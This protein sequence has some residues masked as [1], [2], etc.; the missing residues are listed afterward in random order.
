MTAKEIYNFIQKDVP[1][2]TQEKWD[3]SGLL[4]NAGEKQIKKAVVTLDIS[5][6]AV[7]F[8]VDFGADI[9]FS[10]HPVIF[11][12]LKN[13]DKNNPVWGLIKNEISAVCLH[14]PLDMAKHGMN[15]I[16]YYIMKNPLDLKGFEIFE[17]INPDGTGFGFISNIG[18]K[19][20][21]ACVAKSLKIALKCSD[22]RY[23]NSG[24]IPEK[25]SV[26]SGSGASMLEEAYEMGIDTLVTGDVKQDRWIAAN[27]LGINL[28]D[29]GHYFTEN[30]CL[31]YLEK[32]IKSADSEIIVKRFEKVP[33]NLV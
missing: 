31:P 10:H 5:R 4:V 2:N 25:M 17:P 26:C 11:D 7:E 18:I 9:I 16:L 8:A 15:E 28:I 12:P 20:D 3:N 1:V 32:L 21:T 23:Y 14:T 24:R 19:K 6:D 22:V 33:Y 29:C 27:N 13:L 30:V